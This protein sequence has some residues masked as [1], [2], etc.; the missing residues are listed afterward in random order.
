MRLRLFCFRGDDV[1]KK[2]AGLSGGERARIA[3]LKLMLSRANFLLLDE[4]TNHL[5]I[6]SREALEADLESYRGTLFIISHDRY[7]INKTADR[8][9]YLDST[10]ITEFKGGYSYY[11]EHLERLNHDSVEKK[12]E[13]PVVNEFKLKKERAVGDQK[14]KDSRLEM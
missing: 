12:P 4:P 9:L 13:K 11:L 7:F 8:I 14:D 10:G 2:I 1:Y 5:D 6:K 3:L